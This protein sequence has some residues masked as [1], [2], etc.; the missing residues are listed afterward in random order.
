MFFLY[1][2]CWFIFGFGLWLFSNALTPVEIQLYI[3]MTAI[4]AAAVAIG[5]LALFAPGGLGVREGVIALFLASVPGFPA[6]LPAAVAVGYRI[7]MTIA[8][9]IAFG[10][11][12]VIKWI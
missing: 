11:T 3:P 1:L 7:I 10:L 5:F 4:L 12:W 6:P 9:L 8:E 2:I